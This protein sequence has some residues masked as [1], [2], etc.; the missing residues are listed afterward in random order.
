MFSGGHRPL[1]SMAALRLSARGLPWWVLPIVARALC[2]Q[3]TPHSARLSHCTARDKHR[4]VGRTE[5]EEMA[6]RHLEEP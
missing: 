2:P 3:P 6:G 5:E 4:R 1:K